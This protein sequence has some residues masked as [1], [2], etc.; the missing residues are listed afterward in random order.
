MILNQAQNEEKFKHHV[1][2]LD[3]E[4]YKQPVSHEIF[5]CKISSHECLHLALVMESKART[6]RSSTVAVADGENRWA[7]FKKKYGFNL[8]GIRDQRCQLSNLSRWC[9]QICCPF[10]PL[11]FTNQQKKR[12][13]WD[14]DVGQ[15]MVFMGSLL[16]VGGFKYCTWFELELRWFLMAS[17]SPKITW[18]EFQFNKT[19]NPLGTWKESQMQWFSSMIGKIMHGK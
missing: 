14:V 19:Y 1:W 17:A 18:F 5:V 16:L 8:G 15:R 9:F 11:T 12:K 3:I 6:Q 10:S 7:L 4:S 13:R 2:R